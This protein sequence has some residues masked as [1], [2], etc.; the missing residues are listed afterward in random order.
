MS[1]GMIEITLIL[2]RTASYIIY[3]YIFRVC[4]ILKQMEVFQPLVA[5]LAGEKRSA[6]KGVFCEEKA[7]TQDRCVS[8]I[9]LRKPRS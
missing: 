3:I 7:K 4:A 5:I 9:I 1:F 8:G 2:E 6:I